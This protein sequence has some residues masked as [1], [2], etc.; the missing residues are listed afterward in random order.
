M[1]IVQISKIQNRRGL[2]Q[3]LPQLAS[4]ELGWSIDSRKLYIG[5]GTLDEGAPV[6]GRTEILTE[7]SIIDF[8]SGF[9][10]VIS[11]TQANVAVLQANVVAIN[12]QVAQVQAGVLSNTASTIQANTITNATGTIFSSGVSNGIITYIATQG[13]AVRSGRISYSYDSSLSSVIY[14]EEYSETDSTTFSLSLTANTTAVTLNYSNP[15][16]SPAYTIHY[17]NQS[18]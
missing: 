11:S 18:V 1:A 17:R 2:Q 16:G 8:T 3:D 14:D 15:A 10:G 5:N 6:E 9:A 13:S 7:F 12:N 4:G